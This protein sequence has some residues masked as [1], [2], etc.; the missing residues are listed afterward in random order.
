MASR[1]PRRETPS[2]YGRDR[3]RLR[4]EGSS[5]GAASTGGDER[6]RGSR[7]RRQRSPLAP[8][9]LVLEEEH[10]T[11]TTTDTSGDEAGQ[12]TG[13]EGEGALVPDCEGGEAPEDEGGEA[14]ECEGGEALEGEGGGT[15]ARTPYERGPASL[16]PVPLPHNRA[17]IRPVAKR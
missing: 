12:Q 13:E 5:S 10:V 4:G 9:E 8:R 2:V 11:A 14:L 3:P 15:T 6:T 16:P 7:R 1:R 17:V